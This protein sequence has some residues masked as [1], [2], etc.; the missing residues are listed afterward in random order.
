MTSFLLCIDN[1][2]HR[3]TDNDNL[4]SG[5]YFRIYC[6]FAKFYRHCSIFRADTYDWRIAK[7][8]QEIKFTR[9]KEAKTNI[10]RMTQPGNI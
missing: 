7:I 5:T 2:L 1:D 10:Q 9:L 8:D 6:F 3:C 4:N